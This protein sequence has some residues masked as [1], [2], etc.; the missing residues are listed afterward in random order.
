MIMKRYL[1]LYKTFLRFSFM[2]F[3]VFR[4]NLING[5]VATLGWGVFQLISIRILTVR[6]QSAFGWSRDELS[7]LALSYTTII[8]VFHFLFTRNFDRFSRIIDRGEL[9]FILLRPVDP[10]FMTTCF[11]QN[12]PNLIRVFMGIILLAA[13]T[14][15][16]QITVTLFQMAGFAALSIFGVALLY[17]LWLMLTTFLVWFP[18]LTNIID[19]LYTV[20]G[21]ARYPSEMILEARNYLLLFILP[22]AITVATPAKAL[23]KHVSITEIATLLTTS[24]IMLFLSRAFWKYAL[25]HY[26]SA[27]S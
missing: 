27:S 8:G 12:I 6:T 11:I 9:D 1:S 3:T 19:F 13:F 23:I 17:S 10:Q 4:A 15:F 14:I 22:F 16:A 18:R 20:N 2:N 5:T 26:T 7:V 21:M 25:R 24:L